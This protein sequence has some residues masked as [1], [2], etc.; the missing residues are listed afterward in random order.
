MQMSS[1]DD[2]S[3]GDAALWTA[4]VPAHSSV[5]NSNKLR[6]V[7]TLAAITQ[8]LPT[9]GGQASRSQDDKVAPVAV[10]DVI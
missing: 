1:W 6:D 8:R 4:L 10:Q 2:A 7:S 3:G 5:I 9:S